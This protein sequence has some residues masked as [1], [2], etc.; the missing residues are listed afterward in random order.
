MPHRTIVTKELAELFGVLS[1]PHRIRIIEELQSGEKDVTTLASVL[2]VAASTVS[3][4]LS[5]LR[6]HRLI[7]ERKQGRSVFYHLRVPE[8]ASWLMDG[9][10]F[11]G[12]FQAEAEE[13]RSAVEKA[14]QQWCS[15]KETKTK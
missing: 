6:G 10:K 8:L 9:L 7:V 2:G 12:P 4:H 11:A 15:E 13:F 5:L 14:R 3:Q 1:H